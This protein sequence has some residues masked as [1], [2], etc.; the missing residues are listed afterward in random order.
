VVNPRSPQSTRRAR[1]SRGLATEICSGIPLTVTE[2]V[3]MVWIV[4]SSVIAA[5]VCFKAEFKVKV[6]MLVWILYAVVEVH[7]LNCFK[8]FPLLLLSTLFSQKEASNGS[9]SQD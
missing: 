3:G 1:I 5:I 6:F 4:I 8:F 7:G 2:R 9:D